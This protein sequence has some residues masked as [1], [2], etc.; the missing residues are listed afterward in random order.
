[1]IQHVRSRLRAVVATAICALVAAPALVT[2]TTTIAAAAPPGVT[3][4]V[5]TVGGEAN[6]VADT[7]PWRLYGDG[8]SAL[9]AE[10]VDDTYNFGPSGVVK[11]G[12]FQIAPAGMTTVNSA[13]LANL[14]VFFGGIP[15]G[16]WD[17]PSESN[18]LKAF[19]E[20]G[21]ALVLA[22]NQDNFGDLP[23]WLDSELG[24]SL[25]TTR[26]FYGPSDCYPGLPDTG[27]ASTSSGSHPVISGPFGASGSLTTYHTLSALTATG[28]A[29]ARY[30]L[31][32]SGSATQFG[33]DG[34]WG[35]VSDFPFTIDTASINVDNI[36]SV[37]FSIDGAPF[38]PLVTDR[39]FQIP[40]A[41]LTP[42][43]HRLD[44][45]AN[46]VGGGTIV[47]THTD[48]NVVVGPVDTQYRG[49]PGSD[50]E[51]VNNNI[52]GTTVATI[53]PGALAAGSGPIVV[54]TDLDFFSNFF[55]GS[56]IGP[57]RTFTLNTFGWIMD[58]LIPDIPDDTY[59]SLNNPARVYDSRQSTPLEHLETRPIQIAGVG[60]VPAN[61]KTVIANVTVVDPH[62]SGY[63]TVFPTDAARPDTSTHNFAAG[64]NFANMIT[65]RLSNLGQISV[66]DY[67]DSGGG[68]VDV[69]VDIVGYT[70]SDNGG[71]RLH[72]MAPN[73][74][75]DTR[76]GIGLP[77]A[78]FGEGTP[79]NLTVRG[80][81]TGVPTDAE[82]VV[83]N[84]TVVNATSN[85][86][87]VTVWPAGLAQP[88]VSNLNNVV[89]I[90]RPNL[91]VAR[92]GASGQISIANA[93]G[94]ADII[95][96][97]VGYFRAGAYQSGGVITGL[98][99]DRILDTRPSNAFIPGQVRSL[100]V[101]G[102][103][104][105]P[106]T[107]KTAILKVTAVDPDETGFITVWPSGTSTPPNVSNLNFVPGMTIPNL[108]VTQIGTAGQINIYNAFGST[109]VLVDV[110]GY[111]D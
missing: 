78:P 63:F 21:G 91:V 6:D 86:S 74:L 36:D 66:F 16:G 29:T 50:N 40:V 46:L 41:T 90:A 4:G 2:G 79:R 32:V 53:E 104:G 61:A 76:N 38:G 54:T 20:N 35:D 98:T 101:A 109:H 93:F 23:D 56:A 14:D 83:L 59:F 87:F 25:N 17:D 99:P 64:E 9:R 26:G 39:P 100:I 18:A 31:N 1:M 34:P 24:L 80:A 8:Y 95:A 55:T 65:M 49:C 69:L 60:G 103:G 73:R 106:G 96:D 52:V 3:T 84:M 10:L 102:A 5:L 67:L 45:T 82:S 12:R 33:V 81:S 28:S 30:S 94:T 75:L 88:E 15:R 89:G 71:T 92:V 27:P 77:Q 19:V 42:G 7:N 37:Q 72:T 70:L 110:L 108:V 11:K 85:A 97:V 68:N 13:A 48:I 58:N 43:P 107:A 51:T 22:L 62:S 47:G 105:I 44:A 57:N 111:A